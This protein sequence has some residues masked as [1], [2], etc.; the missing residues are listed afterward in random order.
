MYV[1]T[2]WFWADNWRKIKLKWDI[3]LLEPLTKDME[4]QTVDFG[5]MIL[6]L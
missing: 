3:N 5:K 4:K 6:G 1:S 2:A